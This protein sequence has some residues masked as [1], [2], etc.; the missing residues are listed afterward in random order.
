LRGDPIVRSYAVKDDLEMLGC[1]VF[2]LL[3]GGSCVGIVSEGAGGH[4]FEGISNRTIPNQRSETPVL[5]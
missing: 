2:G 1:V 5:A 3:W 4:T